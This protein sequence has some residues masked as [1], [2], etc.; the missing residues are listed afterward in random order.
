MLT[1]AIVFHVIMCSSTSED[2]TAFSNPVSEILTLSKPV[3]PASVNNST[4]I[5]ITHESVH[6]SILT[7][8]LI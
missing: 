2:V 8:F 7:H 5:S 1:R 6:K 4:L 3:S